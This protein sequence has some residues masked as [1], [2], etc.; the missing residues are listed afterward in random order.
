[1]GIIRQT[2][3]ALVHE[4]KYKKITGD[5]ISLGKQSV[6]VSIKECERLTGSNFNIAYGLDEQTRHAKKDTGFKRISD[7]EL[8]T[9][10][11]GVNYFNLDIS[12][13][14]GAKFIHN[15]NQ[16]ISKKLENKFDFIFSGGCLDNIHNPSIALQNTTR[17]LKENGRVMHWEAARGLVGHFHFFCPEWFYSYYAINNFKDCK[18]YLLTQRRFGKSRFDYLTDIFEWKPNFTR[19]KNFNYFK[20]STSFNGIHYILVIAEKDKNSTHDKIPTNL[21]YLDDSKSFD[22]RK[23]QKKFNKSK[24]KLIKTN[25]KFKNIGLPYNTDHFKYL[26]SNF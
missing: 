16:K 9:K 3:K 14:E 17:M 21:Q 7:H 10:T 20:S 15:M 13:Y 2:I 4:N 1:M 26:G 23:M 11:F 6:N 25:F 19:K 12:N 5:F 22:W 8:I 18:T 24:R